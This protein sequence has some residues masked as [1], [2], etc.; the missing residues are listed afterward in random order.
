[1]KTTKLFFVMAMAAS[2]IACTKEVLVEPDKAVDSFDEIKGAKMLAN[3]FSIDLTS[4][5]GQTKVGV[6]EDGQV[7]W[8]NGDKA[9]VAWFVAGDL[10]SDQAG[11]ALNT[12]A[13]TAYANHKL[14]YAEDTEKFKSN[15][16]VYEGWHVSYHPYQEMR[17]PGAISFEVNP[18]MATAIAFDANDKYARNGYKVE[19]Y[20]NSPMFSIAHM[21]T[22][23][24]VTEGVIDTKME[25]EWV[26]NSVRPTFTVEN[27]IATD[28]ILKD[29]KVDYI[30]LRTGQNYFAHEI[31]V[32]P[33]YFPSEKPEEGNVFTEANFGLGDNVAFKVKEYKP[34]V[35]S[36]LGENVDEENY[37]LASEKLYF[38]TSMAPINPDIP[39][40][41]TPQVLSI[42]VYLEGGSY[43][44][45]KHDSNDTKN[46]TLNNKALLKFAQ[47]LNGTFTSGEKTFSLRKLTNDMFYLDFELKKA[48]FYTDYIVDDYEAWE[49]NVKLAKAAGDPDP[50]FKIKSD[51]TFPAGPMEV[52]AD[53]NGENAL[54]I[55]VEPYTAKKRVNLVF[56]DETSW[57]P[58]V[59]VSSYIGINVIKTDESA[60]KLTVDVDLNPS[61]ATIDEGATVILKDEN[62]KLRIGNSTNFV[63]NG[64]IEVSRKSVVNEYTGS[65]KVVYYVESEAKASDI[66][67]L[68]ANAQ[69]TDLVVNNDWTVEGAADWGGV[70]VE[71][72]NAGVTFAAG[73]TVDSITVTGV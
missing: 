5:E 13:T 10:D 57:S 49:E 56:D 17:K 2:L 68:K 64:I 1:M 23:K 40:N 52:G 24:N 42:R 72:N 19:R 67:H 31:T 43:F 63:N 69:L 66:D 22:E 15:S 9:G 45:I 34:T 39:F 47:L 12:V 44:W 61:Y 6:G 4:D 46:E 16:N 20:N 36:A 73:A 71:L 35:I 55:T 21:L 29:L 25:L 38:H 37:T 62:S 28:P 8:T 7:S 14:V 11:K 41:A 30:E 27:D 53:E 60:G 18:P 65:G 59:K 50:I 70:A 48:D 26:A 32:N 54:N 58:N 51:V 33:K 3:G